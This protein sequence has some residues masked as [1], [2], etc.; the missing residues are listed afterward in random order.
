LKT[1]HPVG[2]VCR[3]VTIIRHVLHFQFGWIAIQEAMIIGEVDNKLGRVV[4]NFDEMG[5]T[6]LDSCM[7]IICDVVP[8]GGSV[9]VQDVGNARKGFSVSRATTARCRAL[10][11]Y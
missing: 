9:R 3:G 10:R 4:L 5:G 6:P 8:A 11:M 2:V 1:F 7:I